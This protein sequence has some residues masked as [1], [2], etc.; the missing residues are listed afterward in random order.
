MD[1]HIS[2]QETIL[3]NFRETFPSKTLKTISEET[4]IQMT[5]VFRIMNGSEMKIGEYEAFEKVLTQGA[6]SQSKID[7][8]K[9]FKSCISF[10]GDGDLAF[11]E[12]EIN[13]L[14]K[15]DLFVNRPFI[16]NSNYTTAL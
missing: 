16:E 13:H 15:T 4:G 3:K 2:Y 6:L 14:L 7:L 1:N 12:V 8:M 9:K 11:L 5:R 10:M